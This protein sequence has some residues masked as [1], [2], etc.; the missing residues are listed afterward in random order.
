MEPVTQQ[1]KFIAPAIAIMLFMVAITRLP[2]EMGKGRDFV[3][4]L[5]QV[6]VLI[7]FFAVLWGINKWVALFMLLAVVSHVVPVVTVESQATLKCV[8]FGLGWYFFIHS[9]G[10]EKVLM[11]VICVIAFAHFM[12]TFIQYFKIP[13]LFSGDVCGLMFNPNEGSAL[14]ALCF[15]AFL[16]DR[17][18]YSLPTSCVLR[19]R[20]RA[21]VTI[22]DIKLWYCLPMVFFGLAMTSSFNGVLAT[23]IGAIFYACVLGHY[24]VIV[25]S[26]ILFGL[27][28]LF[29]DFPHASDRWIVW[30][31]AFKIYLPHWKWGCGLGHWEAISR[32]LVEANIHLL[33]GHYGTWTR[34]HNT[35]VNGLIEMGVG[36]AV[37]VSGY[38]GN[39]VWKFTRKN[40]IQFTALIVIVLCCS[41]NSM[42]RMNAVNGLLAIT[43]LAMLGGGKHGKTVGLCNE[44][45]N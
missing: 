35:F 26:I 5:F 8:L 10:N 31:N 3:L 18:I 30:K 19:F 16:R 21:Y 12:A 24:W 38:L 27:F 1:C 4:G 20:G 13:S 22:K 17:T 11:D 34:L 9:F 32:K 29:I 41:T 42:F 2:L 28:W 25:P 40:A 7:V 39:F 37:I 33:P 45:C 15:P 44:S 14:F 23:T 36:F 6:G 43:W